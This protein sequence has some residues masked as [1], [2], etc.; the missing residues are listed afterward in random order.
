MF[1]SRRGL[2]VRGSNNTNKLEHAPAMLPRDIFVDSMHNA[3]G[4][5]P[6][7]RFLKASPRP[8]VEEVQGE[9]RT[10][11]AKPGDAATL[12]VASFPKYHDLGP[13]RCE[14]YPA[15]TRESSSILVKLLPHRRCSLP[16]R[17][18][19]TTSRLAEVAPA[20][21]RTSRSGE[22]RRSDVLSS[23]DETRLEKKKKWNLA[24]A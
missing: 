17:R 13:F 16:S 3:E 19:D 4:M 15:G 20:P 24:A 21:S 12:P 23:G 5:Y 9:G 2:K 22:R 7:A 11:D 8:A 1:P 14:R 18:L 6:R 10:C